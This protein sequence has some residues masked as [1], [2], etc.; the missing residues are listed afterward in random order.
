MKTKPGFNIHEVCGQY[1]IVAE[2]EENI[3]FSNLIAMN[4]SSKLMW[5]HAQQMADFS[6]ED[7]ARVLM[8]HYQIDDDTPLPH[9]TALHDATDIIGKWLEAG[10]VEP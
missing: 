6:A 8:D 1:I 10:I 7:M 9:E 4:E 3:D 2:G 5:E